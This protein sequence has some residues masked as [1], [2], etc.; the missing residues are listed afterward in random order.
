MYEVL[1]IA[2]GVALGVGL[3]E[4]RPRALALAWIAGLGLVC[5]TLVTIA[6]GEIEVSPGFLVFDAGQCVA[7]GVLAYLVAQA[8]VAVRR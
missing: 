8:T 7:A 6:S 4:V 2:V 5:G 1:V 3:R